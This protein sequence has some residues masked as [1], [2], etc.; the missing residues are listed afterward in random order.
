METPKETIISIAKENRICRWVTI[1]FG[2]GTAFSTLTLYYILHR[3]QQVWMATED[4]KISNSNGKYFSWEIEI[5]A[6]K[7]VDAH[8]VSSPEREN[9]LEHYFVKTLS[10]YGKKFKSRDRFIA[11]KVNK[12]EETNSKILVQGTLFRENEKD[13]HLDL[14]LDRT[15]RS[16]INPF[17]LTVSSA[18]SKKTN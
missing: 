17:G 14:V 12:V 3:P 8:Y 6:Q 1:L 18:T 13:E 9:L 11:Y 10:E 15:E 4:G 16:D 5:A 2:I 7:A